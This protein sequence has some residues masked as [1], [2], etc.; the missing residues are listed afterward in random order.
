MKKPKW[1]VIHHM[2]WVIFSFIFL[3][4]LFYPLH[5]NFAVFLLKKKLQ[6]LF[7]WI[8]KLTMEFCLFFS[9]FT[10]EADVNKIREVDCCVLW[11][12]N[13][14]DMLDMF[15]KG[16]CVLS[17][18]SL[19]N[20]AITPAHPSHLSFCL[21]ISLSLRPTK[22]HSVQS[23]HL[24]FRSSPLSFILSPNLSVITR[25]VHLRTCHSLLFTF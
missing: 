12:E 6:V 25:L 18:A 24:S 16:C 13:F 19:A 21:S 20:A 23:C 2:T 1:L 7:S 22:H 10:Q 8:W 14:S 9:F 5:M 4:F 17:F 15:W 3:F 11:S